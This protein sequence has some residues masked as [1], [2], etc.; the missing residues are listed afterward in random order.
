MCESSEW[1]SAL[2]RII[3]ELSEQQ[4]Q[5]MLDKLEKI[6]KSVK[7]KTHIEHTAQTIL[8]H[9][10]EEESI[11]EIRR[12]MDEIPRRD[13]KVQ[14]LLRPFVEKPGMKRKPGPE[15]EEQQESPSELKK[16]KT[17]SDD[18]DVKTGFEKNNI[19]SD[20]DSSD[21][22]TQ[23][24]DPGSP[25]SEKAT[26]TKVEIPPWRQSI[27]LL[28]E[29]G[30][31]NGKPVFGKVVQKS[32]LRTYENKKKKKNCFFYLGVA[33]ETDCIKVMVYG[34]E[35]FQKFEEGQLYLFKNVKVERVNVEMVMKVFTIDQFSK[36]NGIKVPKTLELEAQMLIYNQRPVCSIEEI[37][38]FKER[39]AVSVEGTVTEINSVAQ[40]KQERKRTKVNIRKFQ[41]KDET[42][43]IWITLW[44]KDTEQLRGTSVGDS[45]RV[46]NLTTN[47]YYEMVSLNSTDFTR[48][49]KVQAAAV[50]NVSM[51]IIGIRKDDRLQ[52][53]LDVT[54]N[55]QLSTFIA[56]S[57]LLAKAFGV[58]L[59]GNMEERL[60]Q[61]IP[62]SAEAEI[63]GNQIQDLKAA[64]E[65]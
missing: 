53:K 32:A 62:F 20:S 49:Y 25:Q 19:V 59:D 5:S 23:A 12:I 57:R 56:S 16:K 17:E 52:F 55:D 4:Y 34:T 35:L 37:Q 46:T 33:D 2:S 26:I 45:V 43:S 22:E 60:L 27:K 6:P 21:D 38:S 9:Y 11:A 64:K 10:G 36:T 47:C 18:D 30:D 39:T 61:K 8:E 65:M 42:G 7:H 29:S 31:T 54:I 3:V 44:R 63:K 24:D 50:Q 48:I 58:K 13:E 1:K 41:L 51:Q 15:S 14:K 28:K 40:V